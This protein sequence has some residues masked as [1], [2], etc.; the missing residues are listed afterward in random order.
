MNY[1]RNQ[2]TIN[3]TEY[4]RAFDMRHAARHREEYLSS[5]EINNFPQHMLQLKLGAPVM[6]L[7]NID[8]LNGIC[9]GTQGIITKMMPH[10]IEIEIEK[11]NIKRRVLIHRISLIPSDPQVPIPFYRRQ[12]P[13]Q[14][15]FA[16]TINKSQG[17]TLNK[18]GVYL[19]NP[20][21]GH[22]QLY[23]A[24]SRATHLDNVK[25]YIDI[26]GDEHGKIN[27]HSGIFTKNIVCTEMLNGICNNKNSNN[28][29]MN[30]AMPDQFEVDADDIEETDWIDVTTNDS[31][32][33][34][35]SVKFVNY[36]NDGWF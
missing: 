29:T 6:I 14:L 21:F 8:P 15:S 23:V 2:Q 20:V 18:V 9:N 4:C 19:P 26:N 11:N 5:L 1:N 35:T 28:T 27:G 30:L 31:V 13:I 24:L 25:L 22:G 17:Q 32:V 3:T 36:D 16:M 34:E 12:F 33:D 10:L 7:R